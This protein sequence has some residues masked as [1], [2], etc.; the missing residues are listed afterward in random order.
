MQ[1]VV[2]LGSLTLPTMPPVATVMLCVIPSG[3]YTPSEILH[4][5]YLNCNGYAQSPIVD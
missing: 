1:L 4:R 3:D 2:R 5:I